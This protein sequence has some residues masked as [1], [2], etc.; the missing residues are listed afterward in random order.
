MHL[1]SA[2]NS[3]ATSQKKTETVLLS[4]KKSKKIFFKKNQNKEKPWIVI[5]DS[6]KRIDVLSA[7]VF[8]HII[9][10]K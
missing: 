6:N 8:N 10:L 1:L 9:V 5:M 4:D 3:R 7:T 2:E